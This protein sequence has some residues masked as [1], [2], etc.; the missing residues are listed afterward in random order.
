LPNFDLG[1]FENRP[2]SVLNFITVIHFLHEAGKK[3]YTK[4]NHSSGI[5]SRIQPL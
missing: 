1:I 2:P 4:N 3:Y 5:Y